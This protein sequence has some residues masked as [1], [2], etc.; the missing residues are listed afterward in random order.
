[1]KAFQ[2]VI[3][4]TIILA[5]SFAFAKAYEVDPAHSSVMFKATHLKVSTIPGRFTDFSG[6]I[7]ID[8]KDMT[9]STVEFTVKVDSVNTAVAKRDDHLKSADF[10]DAKK[11]PNAT[12][13]STGLKKDGN[14]EWEVTG[15][16]T[17]RGVTKKATFE[18]EKLGDV[19]DPM[20]KKQ[21][22]VFKGEA[23]INRKDFGVNYGEDAVVG[24][25]VKL[26]VNLEAAA[27]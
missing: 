24:D 13:K 12:F 10:F 26:H 19:T 5:S 22:I 21:K 18:V 15:D 23:E 14:N 9:K 8:E 17:I 27:K 7:N 11:Y 2:S 16:L 3:F 4:S 1:M 25:K 6:T 20:M